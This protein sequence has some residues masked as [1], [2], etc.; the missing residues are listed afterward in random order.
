MSP[1]LRDVAKFA[2]VSPATASRALNGHPQVSEEARRR[3]LDAAAALGYAVPPAGRGRVPGPAGQ[4]VALTVPDVS[5]PFYCAVL[6]GVEGEAFA[7]GF[8]LVLYTTAGRSHENVL[9]RIVQTKSVGGVIVVTPRHHEDEALREMGTR[10]PV[11]VVAHRAEGSGFPHVTVD[12][13]RAAFRATRYL[14]ERGHRRI[15]FIAGPLSV[16]SARDRLRGY[17]LALEEA[18]I[19]YDPALVLE[20]DFQQ[21]SGERLVRAWSEQHRQ[22]DAWFCSNDLMAAGAIQALHAL[23]RRVPEDVAVMGF[24]DLVLAELVRPRLTTVRQPIRE[25]GQTAFRMLLRLM[26]GERLDTERV[27]LDTELVV[28]ES[29]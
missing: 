26:R 8:D 1:T 20:G 24:D 23:G 10:L 12:N 16:E 4:I 5:S 21:P 6:Q 11:V 15:G 13:L 9:D 7:N 25:M 14:I 17:R 3:V 28:R 27:V 18:G 2:G 22:P 19:G 29:A